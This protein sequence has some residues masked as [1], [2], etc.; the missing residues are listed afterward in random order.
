MKIHKNTLTVFSLNLIYGILL[1]FILKL[2]IGIR[3]QIKMCAIFNL[4][5]LGYTRH[6]ENIIIHT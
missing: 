1:R 3:I 4:V 2:T 5:T 6:P